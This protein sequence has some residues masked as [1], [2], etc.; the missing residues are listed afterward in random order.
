MIQDL[1]EKVAIVTGAASGIGKAV[2][3]AFAAESM[4][5]VLADVNAEALDTA[6][7]SLRRRGH[8]VMGVPT[9]VA[10]RESVEALCARAH[11]AYGRVHLLH[12]NAGV[13]GPLT[14]PAWEASEEEWRWMLGVNL[15]GVVHCIRAFV[16]GMLAHGEEGHVVITAST[17]GIAHSSMLYS[18]TKHAAVSLSE[19][20]Y[21]GLRQRGS[22]IGVTCLCPG[23][24]ST[25]LSANSQALRPHEE[26][27]DAEQERQADFAERFARS[28]P[29]EHVASKVLESVRTGMF[30]TIT[31]DEWDDRF[32]GRFDG[33]LYRRNPEVA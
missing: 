33:I 27:T 17:S 26:Q 28:R 14:T 21:S 6:V 4:K 29:A 11:D 13:L 8:E 16:P 22:R 15:W 12:A 7:Q 30:W 20:L 1:S 25:N 31:D 2:A 19:Y 23:V 32:R 9:D 18:V 3:S 5:V 10:S 24:T